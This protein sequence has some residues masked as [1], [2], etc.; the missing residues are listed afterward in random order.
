MPLQ[1]LLFY[2]SLT[3]PRSVVRA[4]LDVG[5]VME[6][7]CESVDQYIQG[8]KC[9]RLKSC[10]VVAAKAVELRLYGFIMELDP[11]HD[12]GQVWGF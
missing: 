8:S 3:S 12:R 2:D 6:H 1:Q 9:C 7:F 4:L 11:S 10:R 5:V